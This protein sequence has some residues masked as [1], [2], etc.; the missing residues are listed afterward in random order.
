MIRLALF[1]PEIAQNTGTLLRLGACLGVEL[2]I[3]EPCGF[4]LSD[5]N[6]K[7]AGMDYIE[8]SSFRRHTNISSFNETC[9]LE[10]RRCIYL[11]P[12]AETD[13]LEM[14]Y[15]PGDTL[16]LG[17]ESSGIPEDIA[18][19][20]PKRVKISM[21]PDRRSLNVAIAGAIVLSE[22]LRQLRQT[23]DNLQEQHFKDPPFTV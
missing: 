23:S 13:Y 21:Q 15:H 18:R 1:E 14:T 2:D 20:F 8:R 17:R 6:L 4:G 7:R 10:N 5:T 19:I 11:C 3:I 16:V 12:E 9:K 22:A